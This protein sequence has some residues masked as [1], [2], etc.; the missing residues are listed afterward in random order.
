MLIA[1][2]IAMLLSDMLDN[3]KGIDNA[4]VKDFASD[5]FGYIENI[6]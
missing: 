2:R 1:F 4:D 5:S 6:K 3:G